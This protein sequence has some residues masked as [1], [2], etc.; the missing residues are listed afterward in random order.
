MR[1]LSTRFFGQ[2]RL[3]NA[4]VPLGEWLI[5]PCASSGCVPERFAGQGRLNGSDGIGVIPDSRRQRQVRVP[6]GPGVR[7]EKSDFSGW[8]TCAAGKFDI[9]AACGAVL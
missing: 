9:G 7:A 4:Y 3:T 5:D 6:A 8:Q 1:S 2:P